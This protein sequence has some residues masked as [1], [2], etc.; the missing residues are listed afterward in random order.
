MVFNKLDDAITSDLS[1]HVSNHRILYSLRNKGWVKPIH[2][3]NCV[4]D[5]ALWSTE[6]SAH[7]PFRVS[8]R[9]GP[10]TC[11]LFLLPSALSGAS[12]SDP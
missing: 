7:Y 2:T 10:S 8:Q 4:C 12:Q 1:V 11:T 9:T 3:G 5:C 6:M